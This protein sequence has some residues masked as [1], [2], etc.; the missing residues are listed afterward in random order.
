MSCSY[1][2]S[3]W[4]EIDLSHIADN[5]KELKKIVRNGIK[6]MAVVKADGYSRLVSS[7]GEMLVRGKRA[8]VVG[9]VCMDQL[10]LDVTDIDNIALDDEVVIIGTQDEEN[11]LADEPAVKA[12]TIHYEIV[13]SIPARVPKMY[14]YDSCESGTS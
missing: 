3:V 9:R 6:F 8:R 10:V 5:V 7:K 4:E 14:K 2:H 1:T 13:S 11:I 12:E